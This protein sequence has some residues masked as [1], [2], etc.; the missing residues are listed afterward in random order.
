MRLYVSL[1]SNLGQRQKSLDLALSALNERVGPLVECSSFYETLPVGFVS[2]HPFLNA[3]A[4]FDTTL[5]PEQLLEITQEIEREL[6][7]TLKSHDGIHYDRTID[8]DLLLLDD[9]VLQLP[10]LIL[11]HP[12][13]C[14]RLFVLEPLAE[15]A[16]TLRH[17]VNGQTIERLLQSMMNGE[18]E[19]EAH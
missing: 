15:I 7:R 5:P 6:G 12:R 19:P 9:I 8:I 3:V 17:P 2:E 4:I 10:H 11:P 14:E 1:G 18:E 13:M 16:P